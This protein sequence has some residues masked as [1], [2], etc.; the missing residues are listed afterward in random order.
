[1]ENLQFALELKKKVVFVLAG[2]FK[3]VFHTFVQVQITTHTTLYWM[4]K[5]SGCQ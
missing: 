2:F 1:M 3:N 4:A 5:S